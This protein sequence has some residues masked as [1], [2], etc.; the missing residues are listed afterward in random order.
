MSDLSRLESLSINSS[1]LFTP[2]F[3]KILDANGQGLD[4]LLDSIYVSINSTNQTT[5]IK[6]PFTGQT[7][8]AVTS[9]LKNI[10]KKGL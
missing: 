8:G 5:E 3:A 9:H 2:H 7:I 1:L 10:R 4:A 6:N